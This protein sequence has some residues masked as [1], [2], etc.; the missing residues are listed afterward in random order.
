MKRLSIN[1]EI[2]I[3][4]ILMSAYMEMNKLMVMVELRLM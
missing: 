4:M 1:K 3:N 2:K